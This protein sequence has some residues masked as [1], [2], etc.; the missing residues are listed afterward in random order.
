[1]ELNKL[2]DKLQ[3]AAEVS[4]ENTVQAASRPKIIVA[5]G[6]SVL[7]KV[8]G[9]TH[10]EWFQDPE[11]C[12]RSQMQWKL[13]WH[14]I[15]RD[16]TPITFDLGFDFGV[17]LEPS[18]F[19][20]TPVFRDADDPWYGDPVIREIHDLDRLELPDFFRSGL[21]PNI[22]R[23]YEGMQDLVKGALPVR[24]PGWARG[25][26]SVACMLRGF[27]PLYE[28]LIENPEFVHRLMRFIVDARIHFEKQRC[29]FLGIAVD[30]EDYLWPYV[31]YPAGDQ[32]RPVQ[33]RGGRQPDLPGH[34]P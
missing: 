5:L 30:N 23:H 12:A 21:M 2:I 20:V 1:M 11:V 22:H 7:G 4:K 29:R 13:F 3:A 19:G 6:R 28:D 8:L 34:V 15:I 32:F 26:W 10:R 9:F 31:V 18:L 25:P 16:D 27:T 17:A 24:F 33:R 14:E